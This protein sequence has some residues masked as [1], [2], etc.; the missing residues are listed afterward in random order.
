MEKQKVILDVDTGTD[1]AV[2][3]ML[4][5][6]AEN[7]ELLGVCSVNGNRGIEFTTENTLRVVDYLGVGSKVPVFRGCSLPMVSTLTPGRRD[8]IP[9]TGGLDENNI[10][11]DYVELPPATIDT[12]K[13]HAVFW[14]IDTLMKSDGDITLVPV[15][16]LTNIAMAMRI[17]PRIVEKIKSIVIMGGGYREVNI[18]PA[19][20][21]NFWVDPEAAKIVMDSGCDITIVPLDATHKA[22]LSLGDADEL[23]ALGT[24][25]GKATA[26][27]IR[28][29]QAGY[30]VW[31]PMEDIDTVP[32]HDALA[33][34]AVLNPDVLKDVVETYVDI[35]VAGGAADGMSICD[36]DKRYKDQKPNAKVALSADKEVF[37]RMVKEILGKSEVL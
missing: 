7:I 3:I 24:L 2:A 28:H 14:L 15:G 8:G 34:C 13:E 37:R 31:Q 33:V 29:R 11:G 10:H 1:D 22:V 26:Q 32:I 17:E 18:T 6:L 27:F 9:A 20:E 21:F 36:L 19:A 25:A 23:S 35:D 12:Q 16:P 30:K 4:A 5:A